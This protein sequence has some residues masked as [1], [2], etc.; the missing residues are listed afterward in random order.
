MRKII[1]AAATILVFAAPAFA[2]KYDYAYGTVPLAPAPLLPSFQ[3]QQQMVQ[4]PAQLAVYAPATLQMV[5][6]IPTYLPATRAGGM[7]ATQAAYSVAGAAPV[8]PVQPG[9]APA[10]SSYEASSSYSYSAGGTVPVAAAPQYGNA[11]APQMAMQPQPMMA[12]APTYP[13]PT[14]AMAMQQP[15][16]PQA[17][18]YDMAYAQQAGQAYG[19]QPAYGAGTTTTTTQQS[20]YQQSSGTGMAP[21]PVAVDAQAGLQPAPQ[22][23]YYSNQT[24][25]QPY[26]TADGTPL[27]SETTPL[28]A[29]E[30]GNQNWYFGLRSGF[31]LPSDTQFRTATA[32]VDN[33]YKTGWLLGMMLG[34]SFRPWAEWVAPRLE[35]DINFSQTDIDI[36]RVNGVKTEDP[37]A[38]GDVTNFDFLINAFLDFKLT[39]NIFPYIGGGVGLGFTDFDRHGTNAGGVIMD[40]NGFGFAWQG[41]AGFAFPV[42]NG[43]LLDVGYRFQQ[44]PDIE[45]TS[46][47]GTKTDVT[48]DQH[49]FLLGLRQ[50][51]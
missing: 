14:D 5:G 4:A 45:L 13:N 16:Q 10:G 43:T 40:D 2:D 41:G 37:N 24:Q 28:L 7:Y 6:G 29:T 34:K 42:A 31:T 21:A 47:D 18:V 22:S 17:P 46:R 49:I 48:T 32:T 33:E 30:P 26:E 25:V 8:M 44:N 23:Y 35:A 39:K 3:A 11:Y 9:Y 36:H 20:Y 15:M 50:N 38:Y 51:F 12:P 1:S 27:Y 19:A